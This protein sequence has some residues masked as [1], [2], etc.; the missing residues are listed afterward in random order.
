M[1]MNYE[2]SIKN[3]KNVENKKGFKKILPLVAGIAAALQQNADAQITRDS[4]E[5]SLPNGYMINHNDT[6]ALFEGR[7]PVNLGKDT[8]YI[9]VSYNKPT[10]LDSIVSNHPNIKKIILREKTI[11]VGLELKQDAKKTIT[12]DSLINN[13]NR[14]DTL[15]TMIE[16]VVDSV[17]DNKKG[18]IDLTSDSLNNT[19]LKLKDLFGYRPGID[20]NLNDLNLDKI[21]ILKDSAGS[22]LIAYEEDSTGEIKPL[23]SISIY[24]KE[25]RELMKCYIIGKYFCIETKTEGVNEIIVIDLNE[26]KVKGVVL[27]KLKV[28]SQGDI[29]NL[30][31]V[32][33]TNKGSRLGNSSVK[34]PG[35]V[36]R[37]IA[38]IV[39]EKQLKEGKQD[40]TT[41]VLEDLYKKGIYPNPAYEYI[42]LPEEY[43]YLKEVYLVN[44]ESGQT[45]IKEVKNSEIP[46]N[47]VP[48]GVY[49][50]FDRKKG[51]YLGKVVI[52][53]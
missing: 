33:I 21:I 51:E 7:I 42:K 24:N 15:K 26:K 17:I 1:K 3:Q 34:I 14:V 11:E 47:N 31:P 38:K 16:L 41:S 35:G 48:S 28:N 19:V 44:L 25:S 49:G 5:F 50:I 27:G 45:I 43:S 10:S 46:T 40:T 9:D 2:K 18:S 6:T 20:K 12:Y 32:K 23:K 29:T 30:I 39:V 52:E 37:I 13:G 4:A 36:D 8:V 22:Y 53:K